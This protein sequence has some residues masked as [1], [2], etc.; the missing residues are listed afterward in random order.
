MTVEQLNIFK[1]L[2]HWKEWLEENQVEDCLIYDL[3]GMSDVVDATII[4]TAKNGRHMSFLS[5]EAMYR[6]K[7]SSGG[8]ISADGL[9][10][11]EWVVLD[12]GVYM[13]HL[14]LPETRLRIGLEDLW[15]RRKG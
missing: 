9:K 14:F 1:E 10:G 4:G 2:G 15:K 6:A 11:N 13:I 8:L 3:S 7:E 12:F 5:E